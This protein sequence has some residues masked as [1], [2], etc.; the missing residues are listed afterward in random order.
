M[1]EELVEQMWKELK[2]ATPASSGA[3][4]AREYLNG[5]RFPL[6]AAALLPA[7]YEDLED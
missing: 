7:M 2:E 5:L 4:S 3:E 1:L 6:L